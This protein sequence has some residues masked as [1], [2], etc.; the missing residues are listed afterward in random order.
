MNLTRKMMR[1]GK[2]LV[3]KGVTTPFDRPKALRKGL[4]YRR[5]VARGDAAFH[6]TKGRWHESDVL[7]YR[8]TQRLAALR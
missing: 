3:A 1:H 5:L 7:T 4:V 6:A 2:R 8:M